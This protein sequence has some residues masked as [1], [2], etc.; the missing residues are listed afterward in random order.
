M[1]QSTFIIYISQIK[2]QLSLMLAA[3]TIIWSWR[4]AWSTLFKTEILR[5]SSDVFFLQSYVTMPGGRLRETE[6]KRIS[7]SSVLKSGRL[8]ESFQNNICL[9]NNVAIFKVVS[10]EN[11]SLWESWLY[12]CS[13]TGSQVHV[14]SVE[15]KFTFLLSNK[16]VG[17][18]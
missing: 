14:T 4:H 1:S 16:R 12:F 17:V 9:R 7:L 3:T 8:R 13:S 15:C 6:S 11:W 5:H 2:L 18:A 10:F